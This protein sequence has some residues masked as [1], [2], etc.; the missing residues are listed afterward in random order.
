[1]QNS[2]KF[3]RLDQLVASL[4]Y[5]SRSEAAYLIKN[6]RLKVEGIA[7]V[8]PTLRVNPNL[9]TLD[10]EPLDNPEGLLILMH[11]PLGYVCS[12][13]EEDGEPIYKLL[14]ER[15]NLRTPKVVSIGRLDKDTSGLLLLTDQHHL[16][17]NLTSPKKHVA[18]VYEVTV[19]GQ[20]SQNMIAT[21][22]SGSLT[23]RGEEK[24]CLAAELS[25]LSEN[26]AEIKIVEG[27]YH[28]VR[29][30]FAAVGSK[31]I[32]LHRKSFGKLD[33][34]QLAPGE[35]QLLDPKNPDLF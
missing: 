31:V 23:L 7:N 25:I 20:L 32:T 6:E 30:M 28:Q 24:P 10:N 9:V 33:L 19:E 21:F 4:G 18:K 22:A 13:A 29:R 16:V 14:P 11:K 26:R 3:P 34:G 1:M 5:C 12:H 8:K 2:K 17:H 35:F 15:W 27:K